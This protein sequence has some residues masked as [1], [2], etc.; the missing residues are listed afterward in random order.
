MF[1]S[2][3]P[4]NIPLARKLLEKCCVDIHR[5]D[6]IVYSVVCYTAAQNAAWKRVVKAIDKAHRKPKGLKY[7]NW[8]TTGTAASEQQ[9]DEAHRHLPRSGNY[10][11]YEWAHFPASLS[12][13]EILQLKEEEE[14]KQSRH[15]RGNNNS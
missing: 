3:V 8:V 6:P 5:N 1:V 12:N 13:E 7:S 9:E 11:E 2:S 15:A 14:Q 4:E 10:T